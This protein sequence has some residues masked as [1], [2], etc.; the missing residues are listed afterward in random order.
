[1]KG[2]AIIAAAGKGTRA[3]T[4]KVWIKIGGMTILERATLPFFACPSVDEVC[5]VVSSGR[6]EEAKKLFC[7]REKP[8]SVVVGGSTRTESVRNALRH[9]RDLQGQDVVVAVHDGA[10]PYVTVDLIERTMLLAAKQGAAVP[11]IP[12]SDSARKITKSGSRAIPRGDVVLVQT[13]QCFCLKGL[14]RAYEKEDEATDDATLYEKYVGEVALAE[15]DVKNKKITYLSDVFEGTIPKVGVG[16]D[17]HP[18]VPGRPLILG[19]VKID[20]EKGL[21]GHS[22]ADVLVHAIMDAVL[23]AAGL[24]DIGYHFPCSDPAYQNADSVELLYE[25]VRLI[26]ERGLVIGNISA[27]IIAEAPKMAPHLAQM[28]KIVAS[29]AGIRPENVKFAATT[30]EKLGIVGEGKG[31]A[32]EAVALVYSID[33]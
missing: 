21:D 3:G 13:P 23:T 30:T 32:A 28:E 19:G 27:T 6:E 2:I 1:M 29:A 31:I 26:R 33:V 10:R 15:G 25:V 9:Y 4:D 16:F 7:K 22:D 8:C 20:F 17:V 12:C 5:V 18:L 24:P 11:V 14:L